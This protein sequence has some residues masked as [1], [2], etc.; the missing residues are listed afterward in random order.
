MCFAPTHTLGKFNKTL[1]ASSFETLK[2]SPKEDVH[3]LGFVV[4]FE[5][6]SRVYSILN[7]ITNI[8]NICIKIEFSWFAKAA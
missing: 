2:C 6:Q 8:Q 5:K 1:W 4:C 3:S 7:Q